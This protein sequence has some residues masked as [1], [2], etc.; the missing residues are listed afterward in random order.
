M[1]NPQHFGIEL[2][3][4]CLA[5]LNGLWDQAAR[6][7]GGNQPELG[8][9]TSTFLLSMSMPILNLP[10]ERIERQIGQ[11]DGEGYAD[12]RHINGR[13]V[14]AFQRTIQQGTLSQAPFYKQGAW[15]FFQYRGGPINIARELPEEVPRGLDTDE[16]ATNAGAMPASQ[17]ISVLRNALAHSGIAYLDE[18]GRSSY[19]QPVKMY[20][21]V[22]GKF[23]PGPCPHLPDAACRGER[24]SLI[25]LNFLRIAETDYRAFLE[26]WVSWL[27]EAEIVNLAA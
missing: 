1:G 24:G 21:F 11:G 22:S 4:R 20:A 8:P 5:L 27:Q 25:A 7:Y 13:A 2:P 12:D 15:R 14:E 16:A 9:L 19:G 18:R 26:L 23:D 17:W 10:V 3:Q 6:T